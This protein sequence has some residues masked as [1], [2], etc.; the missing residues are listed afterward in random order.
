MQSWFFGIEAVFLQIFCPLRELR[1]PGRDEVGIAVG[2]RDGVA[3]DQ[4][5]AAFLHRHAF[6]AVVAAEYQ[7][8]GAEIVR[9]VGKLPVRRGRIHEHGTS[10]ALASVGLSKI[11]IGSIGKITSTVAMSPLL[12]FSL[13][14]NSGCLFAS[15]ASPLAATHSR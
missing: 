11:Q 4:H 8:I 3:K 15:A 7:R 14:K 13:V 1:P 6:A 5:V 10:E 9:G 2:M 12:V